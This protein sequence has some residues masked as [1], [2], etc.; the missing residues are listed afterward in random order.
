M[1]DPHAQDFAEQVAALRPM[2][3][4]LARKRLR[5]EAWAEDA[6]SETVVAAL[7]RPQAYGGRAQTHTWLVGILKHKL[8]DQ[9]RRHTRESQF[10]ALDD[11]VPDIDAL[12]AAA[13]RQL[14]APSNDPLAIL[15]RRQ[16][17]CQVDAALATLPAKQGR[18]FVMC[19][20]LEQ[21]TGEVCRELGVSPN[22]LGVM[23]H[24]ARGR[25]R[26]AMAPQWA[27][28]AALLA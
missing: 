17:V 3:V 25:L 13:A 22:H 19:D 7:E 20:W 18:A 1:Q 26:T 14:P 24:R 21:G 28:G 23:R 15:A 8:V 11:D 16:F 9:V 5:N 4:R 10:E 27:G 12:I 6:V 2:L